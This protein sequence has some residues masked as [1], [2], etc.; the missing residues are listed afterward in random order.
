M[1]VPMWVREIISVLAFIAAIVSLVML[2][3]LTLRDDP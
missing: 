1:I 3:V 2:I